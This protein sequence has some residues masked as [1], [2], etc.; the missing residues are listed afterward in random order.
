MAQFLWWL[1]KGT[2]RYQ[3]HLHDFFN[4]SFKGSVTI[5]L[6]EIC[7]FLSG[8]SRFRPYQPSWRPE[9]WR[10]L[11]VAEITI[12]ENIW[13]NLEIYH[14]YVLYIIYIYIYQLYPSKHTSS[15][16]DHQNIQ[17]PWNV[18]I[19]DTPEKSDSLRIATHGLHSS[20]VVED[21][22]VW[23]VQD[24]RWTRRWYFFRFKLSPSGW[25]KT[26]LIT[27]NHHFGIY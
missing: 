17:K 8:L 19:N 2:V 24:L 6:S 4:E 13:L 16:N 5:F 3:V 12:H 27:S 20:S 22:F 9:C 7:I 21:L 1:K 23:I 10:I 15:N 11:A 18:L 26:C 14:K 25:S